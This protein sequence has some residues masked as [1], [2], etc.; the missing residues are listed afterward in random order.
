LF[1]WKIRTP[2][3]EK[4]KKNLKP[5]EFEPWFNPSRKREKPTYPNY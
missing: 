4:K 2:Q 1:F 5:V 3:E